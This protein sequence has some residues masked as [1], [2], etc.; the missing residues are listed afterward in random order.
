MICQTCGRIF[1]EEIYPRCPF[2]EGR[3]ETPQSDEALA[4]FERFVS[5]I[6]SRL[7][8]GRRVYG[9]D[10]FN[11]PLSRTPREIQDELLDVCGWSFI[12]WWRIEK[13]KR[14]LEENI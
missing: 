8:T 14:A 9:D 5:D 10:S 6:H 11:G 4:H 2:C 3:S 1:E 13:L 7:E 12:L